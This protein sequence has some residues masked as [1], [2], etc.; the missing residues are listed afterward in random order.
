MW[1]LIMPSIV[2]ILIKARVYSACS[3]S[4]LAGK[5]AFQVWP[6]NRNKVSCWHS[7]LKATTNLRVQ[8]CDYW[9]FLNQLIE[10]HLTVG[11][12][13]IQLSTNI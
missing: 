9:E 3:H 4:G 13:A 2:S 1:S 8:L 7:Q 10:K 11:F 5:F 6:L 12:A